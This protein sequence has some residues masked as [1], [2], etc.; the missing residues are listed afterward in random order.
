MQPLKPV[1]NSRNKKNK[2]EEVHFAALLPRTIT[3][4]VRIASLILDDPNLKIQ[5]QHNMFK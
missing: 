1:K 2:V 5:Q 3:K 4:G